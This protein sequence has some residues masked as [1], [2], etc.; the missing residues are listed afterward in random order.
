MC[1]CLYT[2]TCLYIVNIYILIYT[3]LRHSWT[4]E[5]SSDVV[6][7]GSEF[8]VIFCSM[9]RWKES[10]RSYSPP[11]VLLQHWY[12]ERPATELFNAIDWLPHFHQGVPA[13][14]WLLTSK[15]TSSS[16][17]QR[18]TASFLLLVV[19][20]LPL[21]FPFPGSWHGRGSTGTG[22]SA[23]DVRHRL[24][25]SS[26]MAS[27]WWL[28]LPD[29][30]STTWKRSTPTSACFDFRVTRMHGG[31]EDSPVDAV[32]K[33][34]NFCQSLLSKRSAKEVPG[35]QESTK[36]FRRLLPTI[37]NCWSKRTS[38]DA[39]GSGEFIS[40]TAHPVRSKTIH[41]KWLM[42]APMEVIWCHL[43]FSQC[44]D[45]I[46]KSPEHLTKA[47]QH[48]IGFIGLDDCLAQRSIKETYQS[49]VGSSDRSS[50]HE[51]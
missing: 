30:G 21:K 3:F 8:L 6:L 11:P 45:S 22:T 9:H 50:N 37:L 42:P 32:A 27:R 24:S 19:E 7:C 49:R 38:P 28:P 31:R 48:R 13:S 4:H 46:C 34:R 18:F 47:T 16:S 23:V 44:Q 1:V 40:D 39:G 10:E 35:W 20:A 26:L 2:L 15:V 41:F 33:F 25:E 51:D 36:P 5:T 29:M 12:P 14:N 43:R 17:L